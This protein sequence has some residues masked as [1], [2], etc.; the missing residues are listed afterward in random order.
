M[1][2]SRRGGA[3]RLEAAR[4]L[5]VEVVDRQEHVDEILPC[6]RH[7]EIE[8]ALD[9]RVLGDDADRVVVLRQHLQDAACHLP[10]AL[11]RLVR[12][13]VRAERNHLA[14]VGR[15][16]ELLPQFLRCVYLG[17]ETRLEVDARRQVAVGV[18]RTGIAVD[19]SMKA[20]RV[21][22]DRL[23]E[24][25]IRRVVAGNDARD[26]L[27]GHDGLERLLFVLR[28]VPAIIERFALLV[29]EAT[30][31][32]D[33]RAAALAGVGVLAAGGLEGHRPYTC[34]NDQ[35]TSLAAR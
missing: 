22:I 15:S 7:E 18:R 24:R 23:R 28:R 5:V 21:R 25:N 31:G 6:H 19:T 29:L 34:M 16:R 11:D 26:A 10:L 8:V 20:S 30:L 13:G 33:A 3:T 2:S 14:A 12:I 1:A 17:E 35:Y 9:H 4:E 32:I 27:G